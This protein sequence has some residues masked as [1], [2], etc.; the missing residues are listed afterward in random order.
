[1]PDLSSLSISVGAAIG[2]RQR[3]LEEKD[4]SMDQELIAREIA[5]LGFLAPVGEFL[6]KICEDQST[7]W[8]EAHRSMAREA[9][10]ALARGAD[11]IGDRSLMSIL[12][13]AAAGDTAL[14][15]VALE[16][17]EALLQNGV[18]LALLSVLSSDASR[19]PEE[20]ALLGSRAPRASR[21]ALTVSRQTLPFT[22]MAQIKNAWVAASLEL[23]SPDPISAAFHR[24]DDM[25]IGMLLLE[26]M[27]EAARKQDKLGAQKTDELFHAARFG[28]EE[29]EESLARAKP[30]ERVSMK[31]ERDATLNHGVALRA[32][33]LLLSPAR[34]A[35][36]A[37][38]RFTREGHSSE[39]ELLK[40]RR[41]IGSIFEA[42]C[43]AQ[44]E[45]LSVGVATACAAAFSEHA[46]EAGSA[47]SLC[48]RLGAQMT[49][50]VPVVSA[51]EPLAPAR[52]SDGANA[53]APGIRADGTRKSAEKSAQKNA[54]KS[55]HWGETTAYAL[56]RMGTA[57][58]ASS[59]KARQDALD[60]AVQKTL[61]W[62][63][64]DR[65]APPQESW[66]LF[67]ARKS[68]AALKNQE[69]EQPNNSWSDA[70]KERA[71]AAGWIHALERVLAIPEFDAKC[72]F[73]PAAASISLTQTPTP[74][75]GKSPNR[76]ERGTAPSAE[77]CSP[78]S[79]ASMLLE[80]AK[81][82]A[83]EFLA[84][85]ME[86]SEKAGAQI[87]QLDAEIASPSQSSR[88]P[89]WQPSSEQKRERILTRQTQWR[90]LGACVNLLSLE[91]NAPK[92][93]ARKPRAL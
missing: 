25:S 75:R 15:R 1:M 14:W 34:L 46:P 81:T 61:K 7:H 27:E 16:H 85:Q 11:W 37:T 2:H 38:W 58:E 41:G 20:L 22:Q 68:L 10:F 45:P 5:E 26:M 30:S 24:I 17:R 12:E 59:A 70:E 79:D 39:T 65:L 32:Q 52:S 71:S 19:V 55:T 63:Q 57:R 40:H 21:A 93:Q 76:A 53:T 56:S 83:A 88:T 29:F 60:S 44:P 18:D 23:G 42:A 78:G 31:G 90:R 73:S 89:H 35:L 43:D 80:S 87:E 50:D 47:L 66:S 91:P 6:A 72:G 69:I 64:E 84:A 82:L 36:A 51:R 9:L 77:K 74:K 92:P 33:S 67:L 28:S 4:A 54:Q 8:P 13:P 48:R 62:A 49:L 3:L 86:W